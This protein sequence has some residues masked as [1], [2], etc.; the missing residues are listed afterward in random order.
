MHS[1]E[2]WEQYGITHVALLRFVDGD[3][4]AVRS[5]GAATTWEQVRSL[6]T[7]AIADEELA[8]REAG[9]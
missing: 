1:S 5:E 2:A 7:D 8:R 6:L 4:G 3:E 9:V